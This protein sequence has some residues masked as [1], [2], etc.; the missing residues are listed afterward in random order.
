MVLQLQI[1]VAKELFAS[2]TIQLTIFTHCLGS[3]GV[4]T[5]LKISAPLFALGTCITVC[6]YLYIIL[7][8]MFYRRKAWN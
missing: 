1:N 4:Q 7:F 3:F 5:P 8:F 2:S 6:V